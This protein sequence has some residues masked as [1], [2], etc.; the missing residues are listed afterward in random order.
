MGE[1]KGTRKM[2]SRKLHAAILAIIAVVYL[3]SAKGYIEILDTTYSVETALSLFDRGSM[4]VTKHGEVRYGINHVL[5]SKYGVEL[6]V[7]YLPYVALGTALNWITHLSRYDLI[8]FLI[9][10]SNIPYAIATL[11]LFARLLRKFDITEKTIRYLTI[12]L[13]LGT[14]C[15]RYADYDF[16]EEIQMMLLT[17]VVV[18]VIRPAGRDLLWAGIGAALLIVLKLIFVL[19]LPWFGLYLLVRLRGPERVKGL[20][21]FGLPVLLGCAFIAGINAIRFGNPYE[22]G[23]GDEAHSWDFASMLHTVPALILSLQTGLIAFCP[24]L[25][26]G[27][28]GWPGFFRKHGVEALFCLGLII[29]N[30]AWTGAWHG[31]EGGW[32]WGPRLLVPLIAL[33][34]LPAAFLIDAPRSKPWF[35]LF[36][37]LLVFSVIWQ[38]PGIL[39]KD[40]ELKH[41]R[42]D[43]RADA[44]RGRGNARG[45]R[46]CVEPAGS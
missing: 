5:Y 7:S 2:N 40:Q 27:V 13:G 31:W 32:A 20:L 16:S 41:I 22:S 9:S 39:V 43:G 24:I 26:L 46:G 28:L 12:A 38:I 33:W 34:L 14:L 15:W 18:S 25:V 6:P 23:Y 19:T 42:L 29:E 37:A 3:F 10:F 8:G 45:F 17:L 30:L 11:W 44:G 35:S 4:I 36:V 1:A 21:Q